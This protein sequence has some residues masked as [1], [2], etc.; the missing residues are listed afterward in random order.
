MSMVASIHGAAARALAIA[1]AAAV[2]ALAAIVVPLAIGWRAEREGTALRD[3]L[4][5]VRRAIRDGSSLTGGAGGGLL[6]AASSAG[7]ASAALQEVVGTKGRLHG[8]VLRSQQVQPPRDDGGLTRVE[9][10]IAF[11][12]SHGSLRGF[13][14]AIE[15]GSPLLVIED[16]A[17]RGQP[18]P[19]AE[20]GRPTL[21][22][23]TMKVRGFAVV[24]DAR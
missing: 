23:V 13:L 7:R 22:D 10:D 5:A 15:S 6:I 2:L 4:E 3:Q 8:I 12:A 21:L 24:G 17:I 9:I 20:R 11:Q 16:L 18:P 1:S 14:V 19:T